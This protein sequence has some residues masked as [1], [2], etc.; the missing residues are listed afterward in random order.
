MA[1]LP[2]NWIELSF[3]KILELINGFAFKSSEYVEQGVRVVRITN[4]QKG[5]FT[6]DNPK[7]YKHLD[8]LNK[9]QLKNNDILMSLTGNVGRVCLFENKYLPAYLNQRVACIRIK[10]EDIVNTKFIFYTLNSDHFENM[11]IRNSKGNAQLNLSTEFVKKIPL[12]IPPLNEQKR[13]VKKLDAIIPKV[14][15]I[16]SRLERIPTIL[17]KARQ[18]ILNQA[19]TGELTK[20]WRKKHPNIN[21]AKIML[22]NLRQTLLNDATTN[23]NQTKLNEI[24]DYQEEYFS[25]EIPDTWCFSTLEK[26]CKS[27]KYG[28]SSKSDTSGIVPVLRMGNLQNGE[29]DWNDLVYTSNQQEIQKYNLNKN[30]VLFNRTNSPELVGKTAIYRGEQQA[31][32]AGY[33]IKIENYSQLNSEYLNYALNST[34]AKEW[35]LEVKTDGVSQSNINAQKLA[36]FE[37]SLPP[38]EEQEEIVRQVKILFEKLDKIE[39]SYKKAKQYT[40]KITQ[41][42]LHKAFTGNLVPQDPN[43]KPVN[44][45]EIHSNIAKKLPEK[46]I[47]LIQDK[48]HEM[49]QEI[50]EILEDFPEGLSPEELFKKS[51]YSKKDFTDENIIEFYKE[52]SK[53]LDSKLTEEKDA[54]SHKTIIKKVK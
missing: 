48:V 16:N 26:L 13:I 52:I 40:D 53:L 20:E 42:V 12:K 15:E 25:Y 24:Y 45:D 47:K 19:I 4:V 5:Y 23:L 18:S 32:Y 39:E 27:F 41:S 2:L 37:I 9:Y 3:E 21:T 51:K 50:I 11:C 44:L 7:Y 22:N 49:T 33:L 38:I 28:T 54:N 46:R 36:K 35:K 34:F 29:I 17:K 14:D 10:N 8:K 1:E 43:D 31:I 6:D 30:D